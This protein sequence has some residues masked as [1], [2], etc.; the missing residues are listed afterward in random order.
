[1]RLRYLE[2]IA[3]VA[4]GAAAAFYLYLAWQLPVPRYGA[5]STPGFLPIVY[6]TLMLGLCAA[7]AGKALFARS[8]DAD[9]SIEFSGVG[10]L[11]IGL[12]LLAVFAYAK[13]LDTLGFLLSSFLFLVALTPL[14]G[15]PPLW[16]WLAA[17]AFLAIAAHIAFV[18]ILNLRLPAGL[19]PL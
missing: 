7:L 19:L 1:M 3:A 11:K 4:L 16:M 9:A 15:R 14:F 2:G 8:A 6:G 18:T 12:A 13:L 17:P 10:T 5:S